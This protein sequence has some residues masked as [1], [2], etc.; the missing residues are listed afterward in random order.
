MSEV[1]ATS[2]ALRGLAMRLVGRPVAVDRTNAAGPVAE[3]QPS[4]RPSDRVELSERAHYLAKLHEVPEVRL[5]LVERVRSEMA[6][7]EFD[8][9]ERFDAALDG[10]I[11]DVETLA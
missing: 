11:E 6:A 5:E 3:P 4:T 2:A 7:G 9:P 1:S 10:L 8:T